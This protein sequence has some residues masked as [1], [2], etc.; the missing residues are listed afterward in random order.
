[1]IWSCLDM[2]TRRGETIS[3]WKNV[4]VARDRCTLESSVAYSTPKWST[5]R[6]WGWKLTW[7]CRHMCAKREEET[8]SE[9]KNVQHA[10]RAGDR[11]YDR[12][13]LLH[14]FCTPKYLLI[15]ILIAGIPDHP[16]I[17]PL[18]WRA[19]LWCYG[20]AL[21]KVALV[22]NAGGYFLLPH[23]FYSWKWLLRRVFYFDRYL[24]TVITDIY[25]FLLYL[26]TG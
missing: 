16:W 18:P 14:F 15:G 8:V 3:E 6:W 9:R 1:M 17:V 11:H 2:C 19:I 4:H 26:S 21:P 12:P 23:K 25:S 20:G 22:A 24:V 13:C 10:A 5:V 7:S